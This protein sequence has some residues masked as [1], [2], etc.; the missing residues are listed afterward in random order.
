MNLM[1]I[2][3]NNVY[4]WLDSRFKILKATEK[5]HRFCKCQI[6]I[7]IGSLRAGG[8]GNVLCLSCHA[9]LFVNLKKELKLMLKET[10]QAQKDFRKNKYIYFAH[11]L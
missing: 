5:K 8:W 11:M 1:S 3:G 10:E 2:Y 9:K 6:D 4:S 7:P